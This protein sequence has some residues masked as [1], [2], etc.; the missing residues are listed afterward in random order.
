MIRADNL[1]KIYHVH[2]RGS[3]FGAAL[4]ALWRRKY[5]TVTA[6]NHVNLHIA[7]GE[8]VGILGP[9]GAG[10]TTLVKLLSGLLHPS[11]GRLTVGGYTPYRRETAFLHSMG[12]VMG[13]KGQ[14]IWDLPPADT[15]DML[16]VLFKIPEATYR[17][18]LGE[19]SD[20][21]QLHPVLSKPTRQLS[22]GERM[23]CEVAASLIHLPRVLLLDE[24][25]LGLDVAMQAA[26]RQFILEYN[27][28]HN[29]MIL[30]TSHYVED[31]RAICPRIVIVDNGTIAYDGELRTFAARQGHEK[32]VSFVSQGPLTPPDFMRPS[33]APLG[34]RGERVSLRI[35]RDRLP[36]CIHFLVEKQLAHDLTIEDPPLE[37]ILRRMF[38]ASVPPRPPSPATEGKT[39]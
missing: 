36:E 8:R 31:I 9:N 28:L 27:R 10:K 32:I 35:H 16:R 22:L 25:T 30:L 21:L 1:C 7:N 38:G 23:R 26:L 17:R 18:T 20:L 6:L 24:P 12:L 15:L 4:S 37:E 29:A 3:S 33:P 13:N 2:Q 11:G 5:Q 34:Q 14:L 39:E 19:L